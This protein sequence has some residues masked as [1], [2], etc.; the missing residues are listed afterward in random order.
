M[1]N[2]YAAV[3]GLGWNVGAIQNSKFKG[4]SMRY[5]LL[6]KMGLKEEDLKGKHV[7]AYAYDADFQGKHFEISVPCE[8]V[9]D[10]SK[11]VTLVYE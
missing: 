11:E 10:Q 1:K 8:H 7:V 5:I 3:K 6:E 9:L 2:A 4:V